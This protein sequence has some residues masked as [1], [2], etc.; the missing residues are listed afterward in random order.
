VYP[1]P[2]PHHFWKLDPDSHQSESRIRI[3]IKVKIQELRRLKMEPWRAVDAHN[4]DMETQNGVVVAGF[5]HH[6]DEEQDPDP[7]LSERTDPDP[8]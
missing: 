1:D 7:H 6:F 2:D 3:R 4:G 8:Q 5:L